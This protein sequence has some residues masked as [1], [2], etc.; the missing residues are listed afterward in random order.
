[1]EGRY[2]SSHCTYE[3]RHRSEL[4]KAPEQE[5]WQ[6]KWE[7]KKKRNSCKDTWKVNGWPQQPLAGGGKTSKMAPR[8][9]SLVMR[10]LREMVKSGVPETNFV[11]VTPYLRHAEQ[12]LISQICWKKNRDRPKSSLQ[13]E[14]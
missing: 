14:H 2:T 13:L 11:L 4:I 10:P 12:V 6:W 9:L 8:V 5:G 7:K 3:R 1:M